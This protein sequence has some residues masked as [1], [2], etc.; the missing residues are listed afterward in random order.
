MVE[1][2]GGV[3]GGSRGSRMVREHDEEEGGS[4]YGEQEE[5]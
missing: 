2:A 5:E 3:G 4:K 1:E